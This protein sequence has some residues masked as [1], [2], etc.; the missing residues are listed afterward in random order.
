[1]EI[2]GKFMMRRSEE[3]LGVSSWGSC[4]EL[5]IGIEESEFIAFV[6][7]CGIRAISDCIGGKDQ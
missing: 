2:G 3:M 1:M 4:R 5:H 7:E 6:L